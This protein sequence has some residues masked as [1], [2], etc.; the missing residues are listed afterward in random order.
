MLP[1]LN[2]RQ[3]IGLVCATEFCTCISLQIVRSRGLLLLL[4]SHMSK[5]LKILSDNL[6][7]DV[8]KTHLLCDSS[9]GGASKSLSVGLYPLVWCYYH[10]AQHAV[11][12][13]FCCVWCF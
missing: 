12:R 2:G 1:N 8:K 13:L 7:G 11:T 10:T 4:A 3:L 9:S 5:A 6:V